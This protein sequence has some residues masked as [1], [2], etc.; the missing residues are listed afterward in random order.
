[1][2]L[3]PSGRVGAWLLA[4][5]PKTLWASVAPVL[6]GSAIAWREGGFHAP[7]A[8][9]ALA[10][11]LLIQIGTNL[12]N[13]FFDARR[14]ADTAARLGPRR[15]LHSGHISASQVRKA[16]VLCFALAIV[17]GAYLL[18]R[19]GWPILIIGLGS[20]ALGVLYTGGPA[21][22]AYLGLGDLFA[23]ICF[24]PVSVAGS[25]YV[26]SLSWSP[27]A[28]WAGV[29]AGC[30]S[31]ALLAVN[32]FRDSEEDRLTGKGTL[33][34]RVGPAFV[35]WEF[36][37]VL[38]VAGLMPLWIFAGGPRSGLGWTP[39][40]LTPAMLVLALLPMLWRAL[41]AQPGRDQSF[42]QSMNRLLGLV[43]R[44]ELLYAML[45]SAACVGWLG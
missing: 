18:L 21:P 31:V 41:P 29:A 15:G 25:A 45:F 34:V 11:A 7:A 9:A 4:A 28:W 5:R 2:A 40:I 39:G 33:A 44:L 42:G 36:R 38:L 37:L 20:V 14:G 8:L 3:A 26:Q 1:M 32:N 22:L 6:M 24:G 43:G 19:G 16:F 35:R 10:C 27:T 13:D 12:A 23:F 30:F 17:L